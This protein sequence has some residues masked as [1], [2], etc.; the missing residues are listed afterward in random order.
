[1]SNET[2]Q[3]IEAFFI[4]DSESENEIVKRAEYKLLVY[5]YGPFVEKLDITDSSIEKIIIDSYD[6]GVTVQ[7]SDDCYKTYYLIWSNFKL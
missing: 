3:I 4:E 7:V 6:K 5:M 1:M 2:P